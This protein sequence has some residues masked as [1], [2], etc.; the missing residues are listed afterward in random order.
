MDHGG[1]RPG[2]THDKFSGAL[3]AELDEAP[4]HL[5]RLRSVS[6]VE[7]RLATA[8]L[9]FIEF[10]VTT[11]PTQ[12]LDGTGTHAAPQLIHQAGNK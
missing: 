3:F 8:G 2:R 12:N 5:S 10:N 1:A 11:G 6:G 9:P 7:S 4:G